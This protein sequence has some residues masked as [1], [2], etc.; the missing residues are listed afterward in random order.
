MPVLHVV[1]PVY[2]ERE[3]L[4]TCLRRVVA[5]ELPE[6]WSIA[7]TVIDDHSDEPSY[8]IVER[9]VRTLQQEGHPIELHRHPVNRGKGAALQTGFDAI[10]GSRPGSAMK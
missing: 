4:E 9:T 7:I 8:A 1:V 5:V 3:T 2:N 6:S 10:L